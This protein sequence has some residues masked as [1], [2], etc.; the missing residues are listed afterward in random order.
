MDNQSIEDYIAENLMPSST[1]EDLGSFDRTEEFRSPNASDSETERI[2]DA[3][4]TMLATDALP[5]STVENPGFIH[6]MSV[7]KPDYQPK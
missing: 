6:L 7:L 1:N 3:I 4:M 5:L 2:E